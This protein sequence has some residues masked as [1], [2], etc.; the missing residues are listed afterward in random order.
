MGLGLSAILGRTPDPGDGPLRQLVG[1]PS[2]ERAARVAQFAAEVALEVVAEAF[3]AEAVLLAYREPTRSA[4]LVAGRFPPSWSETTGLRFELSGH[5]WAHVT[6]D[7]DPSRTVR[8]ADRSV[9]LGRRPRGGGVVGLA[10]VTTATPSER[11]RQAMSRMLGSVAGAFGHAAH[12]SGID[13]AQGPWT[14][15]AVRSRPVSLPVGER[16]SAEVAVTDRGQRRSRRADHLDHD[17]AVA[18]AAA[19]LAPS[20]VEVSFAGRA[21]VDGSAVSVVV[22]VEAGSAPLLGLSVTAVDDPSGPARAVWAA[23]VDR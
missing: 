10:V 20:E 7:A 19:S 11:D 5:L 3:E 18:H 17:L 16:W 4:P 14:D 9:W 13:G 22:L 15:L 6:A 2:R 21:A 23:L 12:G 1:R 8:L